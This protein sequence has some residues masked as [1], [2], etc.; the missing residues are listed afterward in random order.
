MADTTKSVLSLVATTSDRVRE[1]VIKDGQLIFV[2]DMGRVAFDFK[3]KRVFYNQIAE[4]NTEAE[5]RSMESPLNGYYFIVETAVLWVYRNGWT[6]ITGEPQEIVFVGIELPAL[7]Q[8]NTLY[9]NTTDG[10]ESISVWDDGLNTYIVVADKTHT[11]T[12]DD[13]VALFN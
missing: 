8:K 1:L 2:Q 5:R 12:D 10:A 6:Q 11:I 9:A 7:G 13:V 4:I 3:G